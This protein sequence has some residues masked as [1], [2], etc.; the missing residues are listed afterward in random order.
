[1]KKYFVLLFVLAISLEVY[2]RTC[3]KCNGSGRMKIFYALSTYG[4]SREKKQCPIC[5][6]WITAGTEHTE[7]CDRCGGSGHVETAMDR[8][9]A[10]NS[11]R[12]DDAVAE[13]LSY[14]T[15]G[16]LA[17]Y[18][19]LKEQ[20]KGHRENVD[21]PTCGKTGRC[22]NCN[23]SGYTIDG[24]MCYMCSSTGKC[25][26]CYGTG[27]SGSRYVEPSEAERQEILRKI[28]QLLSNAMNRENGNAMNSSNGSESESVSGTYDANERLPSSSR[29][30]EKGSN[31]WIWGLVIAVVGYIGYVVYR[32]YRL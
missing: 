23:G 31:N 11:S 7:P 27:V 24:N 29:P 8:R 3:P 22:I 12:Q 9:N 20:L 16:E 1:M 32:K 17:L 21:C 19:A 13:G 25:T 30:K 15:P 5:K 18:E 2:S 14:L 10:E 6:Q 26:I 4:I 28:G